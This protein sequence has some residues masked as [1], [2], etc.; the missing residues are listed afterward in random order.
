MEFKMKILNCVQPKQV[1]IEIFSEQNHIIEP[2][3]QK[4]NHFF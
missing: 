3:K 1:G 4:E 2:V